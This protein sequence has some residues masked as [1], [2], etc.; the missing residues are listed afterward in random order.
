MNLRG[1]FITDEDGRFQ[2]P[3]RRAGAGYPIP[4]DGPVGDLVCAP[5]AAT[6]SGRRICTS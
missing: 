2:F 3:Q 1:K 4:I 5:T 6:T